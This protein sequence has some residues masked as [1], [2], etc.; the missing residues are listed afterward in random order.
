MKIYVIYDEDRELFLE[1]RQGGELL[2]P[3]LNDAR[4]FFQQEK[5]EDGLVTARA[6]GALDPKVKLITLID[7]PKITL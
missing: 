7:P 4:L 1:V 6:C 5:A 3:D 2:T